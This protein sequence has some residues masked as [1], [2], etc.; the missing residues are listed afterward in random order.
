MALPQERAAALLL[1]ALEHNNPDLAEYPDAYLRW[2]AASLSAA[3]AA[4]EAQQPSFASR[5][6][7]LC[8]NMK[9]NHELRRQLCARQLSPEECAAMRTTAWAT[10]ALQV[11]RKATAQKR[12]RECTKTSMEGATLTRSVRCRTCGGREAL[13]AHVGTHKSCAKADTWGSKDAEDRHHSAM[14]RCVSC[15]TEWAADSDML[16][17]AVVEDERDETKPSRAK[18]WLGDDA[19]AEKAGYVGVWEGDRQRT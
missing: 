1:A 13:F 11:E 14:L 6:R 19:P 10:E 15:G 5:V 17:E 16:L 9:S 8:F 12:V 2:L 4:R 18:A 3:I 7:S